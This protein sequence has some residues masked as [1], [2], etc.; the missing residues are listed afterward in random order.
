MPFWWWELRG[1]SWRKSGPFSKTPVGVLPLKVGEMDHPAVLSLR[2]FVYVALL[3]VSFRPQKVGT[4]I[5]WT[6]T[7]RLGPHF[8]LGTLRLPTRQRR[9]S[10]LLTY[11]DLVGLQAFTRHPR[12]LYLARFT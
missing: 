8:A 2:R 1:S 11:L 12:R 10:P 4:L 3:S 5:I 7:E 9:L 6:P